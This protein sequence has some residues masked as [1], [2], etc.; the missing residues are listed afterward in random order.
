MVLPPS[1]PRRSHE[2][3]RPELVPTL[4]AEH[5]QLL[6]LF[7]LV[8]QACESDDAIACRN[9]VNRFGQLLREHLLTENRYLYGY[10]ARH[11]HPDPVAA[12]R[13]TAMSMEMLRIGKPLHHFISTYTR[14]AWTA[15]QRRRLPIDVGNIGAIL[16]HRIAEEERLLYPLYA[17]SDG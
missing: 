13:I 15:E 16:R 6:A 5:Q 2:N 8:Q 3:Y 10:F 12:R 9:A 11:L 4:H 17:P 7:S 1:R 14:G